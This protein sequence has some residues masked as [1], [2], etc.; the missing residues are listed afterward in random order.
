MMPSSGSFRFMLLSFCD[1]RFKRR[2]MS[3]VKKS[4]TVF[5]LSNIR[6]SAQ[7]SST[8][9]W[10]VSR[11]SSQRSSSPKL[12]VV[13][14]WSTYPKRWGLGTGRSNFLSLS[15]LDRL[16]LTKSLTNEKLKINRVWSKS[17]KTKALFFFSI[18]QF[19]W[20]WMHCKA[21][22]KRMTRYLDYC[23]DLCTAKHLS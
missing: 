7:N 1:Y 21:T 3:I 19:K 13:T 15:M 23:L 20:K 4:P 5:D 9:H 18:L 8:S 17:T 12:H 6:I 11:S 22:Y 16:V 2:T 10:S 14:D